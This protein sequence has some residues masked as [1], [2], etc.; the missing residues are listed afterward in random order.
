MASRGKHPASHGHRAAVSW[1]E[2]ELGVRRA[3]A[4]PEERRAGGS[5]V[6]SASLVP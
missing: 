6:D 4:F 1:A 3:K 5:L 2:R